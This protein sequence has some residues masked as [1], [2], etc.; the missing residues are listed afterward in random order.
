M[1]TVLCGA[2]LL[3]TLA[4]GVIGAGAETACL[5]APDDRPAAGGHWFYRLDHA[6][7][8]K[9]WYLKDDVAATAPPADAPAPAAPAATNGARTASPATPAEREAL[10]RE[11]L[12][13]QKRREP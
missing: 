6:T 2:A 7:G 8:R 12:E 11:F 10:F 1:R 9:C 5:A 13:W 3:G 4:G